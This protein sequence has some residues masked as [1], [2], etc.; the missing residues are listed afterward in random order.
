MLTRGLL[1]GQIIDEF[2]AISG[3]IRM[4]NRLGLTDLTVYAENFFR[5][6]LNVLLKAQFEN[7]NSERSNAP[8]LDLGDAAMGL[9]IQV[10]SAASASKVNETL[11]AISL[12]DKKRFPKVVVLVLSK[13][14]SSYALDATLAA[15]FG[16]TYKDVWDLDTLAR[17]AL[18]LELD[19]LHR[20]HRIV[21]DEVATLR[22][23]LEVPDQEGKYP[24][25]SYDRWEK[26]VEPAIGD[27]SA[28]L[29]FYYSEY[30]IAPGD[31]TQQEIS[32]QLQDAGRRLRNLPRVSR[33]FLAMLFERREHE[34]SS[35]RWD[36][37]AH[38]LLGIVEREY[39]GRDLKAELS[40][41]QHTDFARI[42]G[43]DPSELGP[44]EIGVAISPKDEELSRG[45]MDFMEHKKLS[46][47][48]VIGVADLSAF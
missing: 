25:Y 17:K 33:E 15:S 2:A 45:F 14:Q 3:Q 7:L 28:F 1:L 32:E 35:R 31:V 39:G 47:R 42:D 13:K 27:G 24:T 9:G 19:R 21:Q 36:F 4:R 34:E 10:T 37:W 6:V 11:A 8:G 20:L 29:E 43:D 30:G 41:L 38:L 46:F 18:A 26:K 40:I 48:Q 5:D 12:T 16:F 22:V 44:P 23:E